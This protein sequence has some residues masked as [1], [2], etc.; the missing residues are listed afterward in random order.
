MHGSLQKLENISGAMEKWTFSG[1]RSQLLFVVIGKTVK[2]LDNFM[3]K[4]AYFDFFALT[5][6]NNFRESVS[7]KS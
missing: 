2:S 1:D 4:A 3:T 6:L 7:F 5:V